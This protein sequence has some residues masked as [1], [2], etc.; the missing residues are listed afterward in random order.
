M[1]APSPATVHQA[2]HEI[3]AQPRYNAL[4]QGPSLT[5]L[6]G[7][8]VVQVLAWLVAHLA[9]VVGRGLGALVAVAVAAALAGL[10]ALLVARSAFWVGRRPARGRAGSPPA[11]RA[12]DHFASADRLA[13]AGDLRAAVRELAVAVATSLG[14]ARAWE[15]SPLT[16]REIFGRAEDV[17]SLRALL[18]PFEAAEYGA[19]PPTPD[20]YRRAAAA[21]DQYRQAARDESPPKTAAA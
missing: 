5:D 6:L 8:L 3:L 20:D 16:V 1:T 15:A 4:H 9:G 10:F 12:G 11:G 13:A 14:G 19:R 18:L 21:A 17:G 7:Q 2:V